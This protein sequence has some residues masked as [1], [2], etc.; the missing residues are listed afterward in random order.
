MPT[1]P[2]EKTGISKIWAFFKDAYT[3]W[4]DA[5][6]NGLSA[7]KKDWDALSEEGRADIRN[8]IQN[9]SLTY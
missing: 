5:S 8:G 7:F 9:G 2:P 4:P 3:N 6:M 1:A